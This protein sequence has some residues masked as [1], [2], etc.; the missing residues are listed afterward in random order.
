VVKCGRLLEVVV[1][2]WSRVICYSA[3]HR[4]EDAAFQ[5][6]HGCRPSKRHS[7]GDCGEVQELPRGQP[8]ALH[9]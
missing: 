2:T 4:R 5:R 8:A 1:K 3:E 7:H 6:A 9:Q